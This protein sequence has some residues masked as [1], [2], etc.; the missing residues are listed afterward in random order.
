MKRIKEF[1]KTTILG[2]VIVLLPVLLTLLFLRWALNLVVDLIHPITEF[3]LK[4][5]PIDKTVANIL[6]IFLIVVTC[7]ITGLIVKTKIGSF[8]YNF[9]EKRILKIAPGYSIFREVIKQFLGQERAPFSQVC[10]VQVFENGTMMTGFITDEHPNGYYSVFVPSGLTPTAGIIYHVQK[11]Y[12]HLVDTKVEDA[13]RSV[14]SCGAGSEVLF[15]R[16]KEEVKT[17]PCKPPKPKELKD[18]NG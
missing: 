7:F 1:F 15:D 2:G 16:L 3:C 9:A 18:Q 6:V 13:M 5:F 12:V 10:L 4:V 11:K 17:L 14:I 8:F